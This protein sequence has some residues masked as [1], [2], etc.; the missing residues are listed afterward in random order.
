MLLDSFFLLSLVLSRLKLG[1]TEGCRRRTMKFSTRQR[2]QENKLHAFEESPLAFNTYE[3]NSNH[4]CGDPDSFSEIRV[5]TP[6]ELA[7]SMHGSGFKMIL[8]TQS[9]A[10]SIDGA[11]TMYFASAA[12]IC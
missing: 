4:P 10:S 6:A 8:D 12:L 1:Y 7:D 5:Q 9:V 2:L 11:T 3:I